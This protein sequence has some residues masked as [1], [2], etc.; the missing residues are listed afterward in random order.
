M[1]AE[2][3]GAGRWPDY[4][5]LA[6]WHFY[7]G[8]FC[9]PFVLWLALTGSVYLFREDIERLLDRPYEDLPLQGQRPAPSAEVRAAL[10]TVG[11]ST[12]LHYVL[13]ATPTGAAQVVA[14]TGDIHWRV[15]IDPRNLAPMKVVR[16]D[17]RPM[18]LVGNLHGN[19]LMGAP[20]S[21][22]VE[23]AASWAI[24][25]VLTGLI[26]WLPRNRKG[27]GGVLYPRL[28][29]RGKALWRDVHAVTGV[30]VSSVVLFMLLSGLPWS[31]A[32][33][34]YLTW[35]RQLSAATAG[36]PGWTLGGAAPSAAPTA[37]CDA[38]S[39]MPGMSAAEM[40]AMSPKSPAAAADD[41]PL[42]LASTL[43][44][45]DVV[46]P[47]TLGLRVPHPVLVHPP[48]C[49]GASW[50]V[51]S[52]VQDRLRRV[53]Y[54]LSGHEGVV[55]SRSGFAQQAPLDRI[56]N[57]GISAHVG[58]LFGRPNQAILLA[59]AIGLVAMMASALVMWLRRKP[60]DRLGA[61]RP[62]GH[63]GAGA[64][65]LASVVALAIVV[66]LFALTLLCV[67][68]AERL[69]VRHLP[70]LAAWLGLGAGRA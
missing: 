26:L 19:L 66:P 47:A 42:R 57:V 14:S 30:W 36:T 22:L 60:H 11:G 12:L 67:L 48:Q 4:A 10:A 1:A 20:G 23:I 69:A 63:S 9:I 7:A 41:A 28:G 68:A 53:T 24:V 49:P 13:P 40:A 58:Q 31:T 51:T 2:T 52:D 29:Q 34:N 35:A 59:M 33:G 44:E 5:T 32:W 46:V 55:L 65:F 37:S 21:V 17:R 70:A 61:P 50:S 18:E 39:S 25:L 43:G 64:L 56:V 16:D 45:L 62:G 8:L 3:R 6:R 38:G 54:E 27:L 15:Y